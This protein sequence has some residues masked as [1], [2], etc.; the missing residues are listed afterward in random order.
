MKSLASAISDAAQLWC[1]PPLHSYRNDS[2]Q[3][4]LDAPNSFTAEAIAFAIDQQMSQM[5][6]SALTNW[7]AGRM[8]IRKQQVG[9][10]NAGN[11][12]LVG[13]QDLLAVLLCGHTYI[14]V[15]SSKSSYFLPAFCETVREVGG[16][17]DARF[18]GIEEI[19]EDA[20]MVIATGSDATIAQIQSLSLDYGL[21]P[22]KC[23][24]RK[25]RYSLAILDGQE[26]EDHL[27]ELALDVLLHEGMGCRSVALI[28]APSDLE[29]DRFLDHLAK[30]RGYFPAHPSTSGKLA[31]QQAYLSA[32]DQSHAYGDGLEF[33]ISKG[34]AEPQV[35]GHVRWVEYDH[36]DEIVPIV[37]DFLADVQCM[38][39][40]KYVRNK[41]PEIWDIQRFG[42]TQRPPLDWKPDGVD[43]I[44]FLCGF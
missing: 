5:S 34:A 41:L 38:V 19:W 4:T 16:K 44:D 25:N 31:L 15:L 36:L 11:I 14:G 28:F 22:S 32:T 6:E 39:A 42:S 13:L 1:E 35:P 9:V 10:I 33:L 27:S 26:T 17:F 12:P 20:E 3:S 18:V 29:P 7:L 30:M 43:T 40:R 37:N 24:F 23:L 8:P 2:V 21:D